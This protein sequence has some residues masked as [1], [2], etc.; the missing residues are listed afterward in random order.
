MQTNI[1]PALRL[2]LGCIVIFAVAY[3]LLILGIGKGIAPAQGKGEFIERGGH[4]VGAV[5]IGQKFDAESYF[6]SRPSAAGY[7]AAASSGSN[8]AVSNPDY[9]KEVD[10]RIEAFLKAHPY[11]QRAQVPAELVTASGS[12]LDPHLSPAAALVQVERVAK[13]RSMDAGRIRQLVEQY[14]EKPVPAFLGLPKVN[15]LLLNI[16]LDDLK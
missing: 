1:F 11:L 6:W 7:N 8:K 2:T 4:K 12:G 5:L 13:A 14:T 15:V 16:A 3:P 9:L 10:G